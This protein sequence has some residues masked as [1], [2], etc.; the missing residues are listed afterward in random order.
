MT[1][2]EFI[3]SGILEL[4]VL[5]TLS[6]PEKAEVERMCAEHPD[7]KAELEAVERAMELMD[8][9]LGIAPPV[10]VKQ[11]LFDALPESTLVGK[12][13]QIHLQP[14]S[15]T[16][17]NWMMAASVTVALLSFIAAL[18]YFQKYNSVS[19]EYEALVA[20]NSMMA[21]ELNQV[22]NS[23]DQNEQMLALATDESTKRIQLNATKEGSNLQLFVYWNTTSEEV[24]LDL[25]NLGT[26]GD[27]QD[28][29]LWAI[30]E[31]KPVDMGVIDFTNSNS[32]VKMKNIKGAVAF[33]IT[34]EP[35]GGLES[36]TLENMVVLGQIAT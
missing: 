22:K 12:G 24:Y 25:G 29:Q 34:L 4:Y 15:E 8:Q 27:Q 18:F 7:V 23:L 26:P 5:G 33:A 32:L 13:K 19:G 14:A 36:P 20:Q 11:K 31:G 1:S 35:K 10:P 6:A 3:E 2:K 16:K 28:Y 17:N 30:V 9:E 21:Q